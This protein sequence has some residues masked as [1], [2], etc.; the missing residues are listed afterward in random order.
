MDKQLPDIKKNDQ[1]SNV[2]INIDIDM[3]NCKL[4]T[5]ENKTFGMNLNIS[6]GISVQY[7]SSKQ[8][9]YNGNELI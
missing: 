3:H 7:A 9:M 5:V 1:L 4:V 8:K 6:Q 2:N